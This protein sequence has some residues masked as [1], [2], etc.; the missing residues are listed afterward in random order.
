MN[1]IFDVDKIHIRVRT[2]AHERFFDFH[3]RA[4]QTLANQC[5]IQLYRFGKSFVGA[6]DYLF[7]LC[8]IYAPPWISLVGNFQGSV[9]TVQKEQGVSGEHSLRRVL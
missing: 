7:R 9:I 3:M 2:P 4:A 5:R 6:A 8:L 1:Q